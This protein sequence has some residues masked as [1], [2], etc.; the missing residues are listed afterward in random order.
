MGIRF[1]C[2]N[3]HKL[4]VKSHLAGMV[5]YCPDCGDR[6]TV[7][8]TSTRFSSKLGG[9]L[10]PAE[11]VSAELERLRQL[12]ASSMPPATAAQS[13]VDA[14]AVEGAHNNA[15]EDYILDDDDVLNM[16]ESIPEPSEV[17]EPQ[18]PEGDKSPE[19][20]PREL[21]VP[22]VDWFLQIPGGKQHGPISG[23]VLFS[24]ICEKRV[25]REML[26]WRSGWAD[27]KTASE[28]IPLELFPKTKSHA[29]AH[30]DGRR[31]R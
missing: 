12:K 31:P 29:R 6:L 24:W 4:N 10:I 19:R 13:P 26:L 21:A 23:T 16:L 15:L 9:G 22:G 7:P 11:E 5:G 18:V 27:W 17:F 25:S 2:P 30:S 3:G 28:V 20:I 14:I 1:F 8:V